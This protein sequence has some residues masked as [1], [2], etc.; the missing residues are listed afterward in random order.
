MCTFPARR[1]CGPP[2]SLS[3]SFLF[4]FGLRS[5]ALFEVPEGGL[6]KAELSSGGYG[7]LFLVSVIT[8]ITKVNFTFVSFV[9]FMG[10]PQVRKAVL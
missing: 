6:T 10:L 1:A 4:C 5:C 7:C 9:T 8:E 2:T 3:A